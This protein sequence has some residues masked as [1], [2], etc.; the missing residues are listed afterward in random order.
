M[1]KIRFLASGVCIRI[2][3]G[4]R[5]IVGV[6]YRR[7]LECCACPFASRDVGS[8]RALPLCPTS[9]CFK[10]YLLWKQTHMKIPG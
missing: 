1:L 7:P 2:Q 3:G 4:V 5:V 9:E 8:H 10:R 6:A